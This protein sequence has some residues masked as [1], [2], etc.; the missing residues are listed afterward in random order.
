MSTCERIRMSLR[1]L[2]LLAV[3]MVSSLMTAVAATLTIENGKLSVTHDGTATTFAVTEMSSDKCFLV[4]GKLEGAPG[5]RAIFRLRRILCLRKAEIKKGN[6]N[7]VC[8]TESGYDDRQRI[9]R[10]I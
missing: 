5:V 4:N 7:L 3:F 2:S 1:V 10:S 9:R 6:L 8:Q